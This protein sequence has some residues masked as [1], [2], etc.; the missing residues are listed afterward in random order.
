M[1]NKVKIHKDHTQKSNFHH[2]IIKLIV[3]TVLQKKGRTWEH[4]FVLSGI[5]TQ[6]EN[7]PRKRQMN[8]HYILV[9]ILKK[10]VIAELVE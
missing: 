8:K 4:F 2:G 6:Q 1:S 10:E 9:K 3:S 7:Q 5:Q